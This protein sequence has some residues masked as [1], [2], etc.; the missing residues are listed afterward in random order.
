M[1]NGAYIEMGEFFQGV[2][3]RVPG[4]GFLELLCLQISVC[5]FVCVCVCAC[6]STPKAINN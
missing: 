3:R 5:M 1:D 6:V 4:H 2:G